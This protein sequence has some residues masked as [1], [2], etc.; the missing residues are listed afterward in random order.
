MYNCP[1][2]K[3]R[4]IE[5]FSTS[6]ACDACIKYEVCGDMQGTRGLFQGEH[7]A[8]TFGIKSCHFGDHTR[9]LQS[10]YLSIY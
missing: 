7:S 9:P 6:T 10:S 8:Y 5:F 3:I 2:K 4:L 1:V